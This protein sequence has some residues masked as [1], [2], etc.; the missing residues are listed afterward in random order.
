MIADDLTIARR[1]KVNS[2]AHL[3]GAVNGAHSTNGT[4]TKR[5]R[6]ADDASIDQQEQS[7][8]RGKVKEASANGDDLITLDD[9]GDGAIILDDD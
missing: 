5:K 1:P 2:G 7:S 8:K 3:N 6:S 4:S 9:A